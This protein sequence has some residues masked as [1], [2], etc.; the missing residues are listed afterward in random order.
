MKVRISADSTCDLSKEYTERHGIYIV[1]MCLIKDDKKY[2]DGDLPNEEIFRYFEEE[3]KVCTTVALNPLQYLEHFERARQDC[4]YLIHIDIGS[5]FSSCH[6]NA[7]LAAE[8][9][10]NVMVLDSHNLSTG[11]GM[12]VL[13]A[14][15]MAENGASP[16]EIKDMVA[17]LSRRIEA[18]FVIDTL[19]YLRRGG[20]CSALAAFGSNLMNI[21]PCLEVEGGVM[22][23]GKKYRGNF[24]SVI[25]KYIEDRLSGRDDIDYSKIF[26]THAA[27]PQ[28]YIDSVINKINELAEFKESAV[29]PAGCSV[30]IHCGPLTLGIVYKRKI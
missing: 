18:S 8:E 22:K 25:L 13:E 7:K 29:L 11:F 28:H 19:S 20:R 23:V 9:I 16:E 14:A 4:D 3:K 17:S 6:N 12:I 15:I 21:K 10:D 24:E 27:C 2:F 26:I 1:P 5:N 30:A